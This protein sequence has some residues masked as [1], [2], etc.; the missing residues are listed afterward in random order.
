MILI[1]NVFLSKL[2]V[3]VNFFFLLVIA[4]GNYVYVFVRK[5]LN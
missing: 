4:I 1:V 2:D 3:N 5:G